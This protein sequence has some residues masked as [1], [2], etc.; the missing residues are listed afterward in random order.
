M[1]QTVAIVLPLPVALA[2][3]VLLLVL[4]VLSAVALSMRA[5]VPVRL[6]A[7]ADTRRE[8]ETW[9]DKAACRSFYLLIDDVDGQAGLRPRFR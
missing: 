1:S 5:P 9:C 8:T 6:P 2:L 7:G 4:L 3:V